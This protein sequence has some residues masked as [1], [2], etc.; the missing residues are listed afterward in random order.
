[1]AKHTVLRYG[2]FT[3]GIWSICAIFSILR[4]VWFYYSNTN[5]PISIGTWS[6]ICKARV[7]PTPKLT[8]VISIIANVRTCCCHRCCCCRLLLLFMSQYC[9]ARACF[10]GTR[11]T[12]VHT[13]TIR[14]VL[15]GFGSRVYISVCLLLFWLAG[16]LGFA[17]R[18]AGIFAWVY[19]VYILV[20]V[21]R[22]L[23][24]LSIIIKMWTAGGLT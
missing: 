8:H 1:M 2:E 19:H 3:L 21:Q 14:L 4:K 10:S 23:R 11:E 22:S 16:L 5:L 24:R 20:Q 6:N 7:E 13:Q 9:F 12:H 17:G 15:G 18:V